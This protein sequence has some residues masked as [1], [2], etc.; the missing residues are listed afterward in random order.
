MFSR[1]HMLLPASEVEQPT[2]FHSECTRTVTELEGA[3]QAKHTECLEFMRRN[4]RTNVNGCLDCETPIAWTNFVHTSSPFNAASGLKV[5]TKSQRVSVVDVSLEA[6]PNRLHGGYMH[7]LIGTAFVMVVPC[8]TVLEHPRIEAFLADS[9][10]QSVRKFPTFLLTESS[11][12]WLPYGTMPVVLGIPPSALPCASWSEQRKPNKEQLENETD[13]SIMCGI[14]LC[15]NMKEVGRNKQLDA[16]VS[17]LWVK[18]ARNMFRNLK[19]QFR[20]QG[21]AKGLGTGRGGRGGCGRQGLSS[22]HLLL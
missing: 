13:A 14:S 16:E 6:W 15:F 9:S 5:F 7:M 3:A 19:N 12:V 20:C 18:A 10:V 22:L 2:Y 8:E 17:A 21:L 4:T 1:P 11:S